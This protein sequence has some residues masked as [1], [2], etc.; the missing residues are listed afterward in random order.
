MT[1][2]MTKLYLYELGNLPEKYICLK[3]PK[4]M[5]KYDR[6]LTAEIMV[7]PK[8]RK[9]HQVGALRSLQCNIIIVNEVH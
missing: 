2:K 4:D 3:G 7:I 6:P 9:L 5:P 8:K 1:Y